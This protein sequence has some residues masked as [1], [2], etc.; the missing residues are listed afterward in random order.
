MS[1]KERPNVAI[2]GPLRELGIHDVFQ[3]LDLSRKTGRLRVTS[4]LRD[5]DG[6]VYFERGRVIAATIRS[7]PYPLGAVLLRA[8]KVSEG[9]LA[10]A[11]A[12]QSDGL[13][14]R[15]MGELLVAIGALT[16]KEL[17]RQV[18]LQ[19]EAVVFELMSWQE[20]HFSF[21]E[22]TLGE[23]AVDALTSISTESLL[24][25]GARRIDE[26][27]RIAHRIPHLDVIPVLAPVDDTHPS[28]LDLLPHEWEALALID[29]VLDL[30]TIAT[31]L[32]R[33][34]FDLARIAYGLLSTG[35][36]ELR[37]VA[38]PAISP[39][40]G[41]DGDT[42][43]AA[44][45]ALREGQLGEALRLATRAVAA[46][47]HSVEGRLLLARVLNAERRE[48][49]A[50]DELRRA[51]ELDPSST[52]PVLEQARFALRRGEFKEA[53]RVWQ[54]FL[55]LSPADAQAARIREAAELAARLDT[56]LEALSDA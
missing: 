15:R 9:D 36:I 16:E 26:W 38:R 40:S 10:R 48:A 52:R 54:R 32:G 25:E 35:V 6:S 24:M 3:L 11:K 39:S 44:R 21:S 41:R 50:D 28:L 47:P 46:A 12:M 7:N 5:N 8:G 56:A 18:R 34:D 14:R 49:E 31:A 22:G 4:A 51:Q 55:A 45:A 19:V 1:A 29:G 53:V 30:R 43:A 17:E 20:G 13:E 23:I 27:A 42:L 37:E 2:E 33:S